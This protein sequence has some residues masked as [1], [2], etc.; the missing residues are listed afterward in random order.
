[1]IN[2]PFS[3][4]GLE[5]SRPLNDG[6]FISFCELSVPVAAYTTETSPMIDSVC[7][8]SFF[9]ALNSCFCYLIAV[10][11]LASKILALGWIVWSITLTTD[12][13]PCLNVSSVPKV[14][15]KETSLS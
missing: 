1:M 4:A 11:R 9:V 14:F 7:F 13:G 3:S 2:N 10:S 5:P 8:L 6:A 12:V 15:L